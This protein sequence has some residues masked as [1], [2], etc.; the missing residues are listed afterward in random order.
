MIKTISQA[1]YEYHK[2]PHKGEQKKVFASIED[3]VD[4]ITYVLEQ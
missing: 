4:F 3:L 2:A 1:L